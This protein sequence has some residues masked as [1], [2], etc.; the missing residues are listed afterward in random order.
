M[1]WRAGVVGTLSL[2]WWGVGS[3]GKEPLGGAGGGG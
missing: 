3:V 2:P 1:E